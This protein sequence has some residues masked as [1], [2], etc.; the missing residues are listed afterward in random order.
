[1]EK[2]VENYKGAILFYFI[3]ILLSLVFTFRLNKLNTIGNESQSKAQE[4]HCA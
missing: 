2:L 3:I 1:M 4:V